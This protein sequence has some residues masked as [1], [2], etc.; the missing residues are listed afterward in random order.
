MYF[1]T[2]SPCFVLEEAVIHFHEDCLPKYKRLAAQKRI[3]P[4]VISQNKTRN[5]PERQTTVWYPLF[6]REKRTNVL[7]YLEILL[8]N[9][10][11]ESVV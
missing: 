3:N 8:G 2:Q 4:E 9:K 10:K 7:F 1:C 5:T 6:T 11:T